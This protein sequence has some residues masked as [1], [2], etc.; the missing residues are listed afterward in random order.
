MKRTII[1]VFGPKRLEEAYKNNEFHPGDEKETRWLKIGLTRPDD[2]NLSPWDA[3]IERIKLES[4]TGLSETCVLLDAFEYP[5]IPG[6]PDDQIRRLMT[7]DVYNLANSKAN[8][9]LISNKYEIKAGQE[10]VYGA[11]RNQVMAAI[12][13]FERDL[14]IDIHSSSPSKLSVL[15]DMIKR[16]KEDAI[17]ESEESSSTQEKTKEDSFYDR[18]KNA[19]PDDIKR[20]SNH[21]P[22]KPYLTIRSGRSDCDQYFLTISVRRSETRISLET[23]KG[24]EARNTVEEFIVDNDIENKLPTLNAAKQGVKNPKKYQWDI[25]GKYEGDEDTIIKWFVDNITAMFN[26]FEP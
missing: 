7:D 11:T 19:L 23:Y 3:A 25:Y 9:K 22:G 13:K 4:R 12:A 8:N 18:L 24:D 1:Y 21:T 26:A 20:K 10:F 6:K 2:D 17:D 14:I 5:D 16:N 15:L